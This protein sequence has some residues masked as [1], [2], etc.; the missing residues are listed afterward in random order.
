[1]HLDLLSIPQSGGKNV[2]MFRFIDIWGQL[3][4]SGER[5]LHLQ[6]ILHLRLVVRVEDAVLIL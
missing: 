3:Y 5:D 2:K 4:T 1:M 6:S